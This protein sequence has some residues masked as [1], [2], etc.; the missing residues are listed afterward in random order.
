MIRFFKDTDLEN[1]IALWTQVFGD[2]D[3]FVRAYMLHPTH[4]ESM[5]VDVDNDKVTAML[6]MLPI[7]LMVDTLSVPGRY[8]YAVA[9]DPDYRG[10]GKARALVDYCHHDMCA[11]EEYVSVLVPSNASLFDYYEKLD[12]ATAF[13]IR[14]VMFDRA[15][16]PVSAPPFHIN[17]LS[18]EDFF[19]IRNRY[20]SVRKPFVMWDEI[21]LDYVTSSTS[22]FE[23]GAFYISGE[24][25][26]GYAICSGRERSV[27]IGEMA[28]TGISRESFLGIIHSHIGADRYTLRVGSP[29][30]T[31]PGDPDHLPFG[32]IHYIET[33]DS[34]PVIRI[35]DNAIK[36]NQEVD[37]TAP[38]LGLVL[39]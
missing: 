13:S 32:M 8:I 17:P 37:A 35:I 34:N 26:E 9:T 21:A 4:A 6:S 15:A 18:S 16:L 2:S 31:I 27:F 11:R 5:L 19:R 7:Q 3:D 10:Q 30:S 23:I 29:T 28:Y 1:V 33:P 14:H 25:F 22:A 39:D 36:A 20:F 12:F 24:G 38:Y